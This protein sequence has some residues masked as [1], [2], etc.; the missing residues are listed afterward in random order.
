M[1]QKG[2][3]LIIETHSEHILRGLQLEISKY[4]LNNKEGISHEEFNIIYVGKSDSNKISKVELNEF[5]EIV[6]DWPSGFFDAAYTATMQ[7]LK[8]KT[9]NVDGVK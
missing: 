8:N 9:K 4:R 7:I 5:G 2:I 1:A 3:K 6:S